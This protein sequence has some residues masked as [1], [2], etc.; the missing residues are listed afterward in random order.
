MRKFIAEFRSER[1]GRTVRAEICV[2]DATG[3][4]LD[5]AEDGIRD[6]YLKAE[7]EDRLA[8][9]N[10]RRRATPLD[11]AEGGGREFEA[12]GADLLARALRA[13]QRREIDA[14][15][16]KLTRK[17]RHVLLCRALRDETFAEIAARLGVTRQSVFECFERAARAMREALGGKDSG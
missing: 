8:A 7:Y 17:Q 13:A 16:G 14:A 1:Y 6:A 2:D 9:R 10:E 4:A 5:G 11:C 15:L 3:A 12:P